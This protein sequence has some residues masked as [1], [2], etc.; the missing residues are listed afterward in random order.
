MEQNKN[1]RDK[2]YQQKYDDEFMLNDE[3]N[4]ID[5]SEDSSNNDQSNHEVIYGDSGFDLLPSDIQF[6]NKKGSISKLFE[7]NDVYRTL[8]SDES[9]LKAKVDKVDEIRG[10]QEQDIVDFFNGVPSKTKKAK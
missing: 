10:V 9:G 6:E 8:F 5:L 3:E 4:M 7:N 2:L 1:S